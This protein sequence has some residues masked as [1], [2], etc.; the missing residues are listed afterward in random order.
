M[1][2]GFLKDILDNS[3]LFS[4]LYDNLSEEIRL[5][6]TYNMAVSYISRYAKFNNLDTEKLNSSYFAFIS[7][8][9]KQSKEFCKTGKYPFEKEIPD[10][11]VF[12]RIEYDIAL[13]L[14]VLFTAHRYRIMELLHNLPKEEKALYIGIGPGLEISL[15]KQKHQEIHAYDLA[16]N[17]FLKQEFPDIYINNCL[18]TGQ[19]KEYFDIIYLIEILEHLED[20]F[21]L[22]KISYDS[23]KKCGKLVLTTATDIPQF[24]HL[25]NFT[26]DD[27]NFIEKLKKTGFEVLYNEKI[28]HNYLTLPIKSSN[29]FYIIQKS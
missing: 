6:D 18:Y 11:Y 20:P 17:D 29:R 2:K 22:I 5:S 26:E 16:V 21:E 14:S 13:L 8:Y 25:Y 12:S 24:D 10:K 28:S 9:N 23:L 3:R 7:A 27:K 4:V 1:D 15:T 19:Y